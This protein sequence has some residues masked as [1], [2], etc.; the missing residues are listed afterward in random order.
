MV[1]PKYKFVIYLNEARKRKVHL[2]SCDETEAELLD[3]LSA[4]CILGQ[5]PARFSC[6]EL[7]E[8][9]ETLLKQH[10]IMVDGSAIGF[11]ELLEE[12]V[13][14]TVDRAEK[15]YCGGGDV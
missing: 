12:V 10:M 5:F 1:K 14:L 6:P 3:H 2:C 9:L 8:L 13:G 7:G 11:F 15:Y 4:R